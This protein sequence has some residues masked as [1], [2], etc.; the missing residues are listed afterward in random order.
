MEELI[1]R[2]AQIRLQPWRKV[3]LPGERP[4]TYGLLMCLRCPDPGQP[5]DLEA[6]ALYLSCLV[7]EAQSTDLVI[8]VGGGMSLVFT[9][10]R[11]PRMQ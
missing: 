5:S 9:N 11:E 4:E 1:E 8:D 6:N 7:S 2:E 10:L 3:I